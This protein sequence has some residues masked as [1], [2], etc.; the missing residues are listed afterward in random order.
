M[1]KIVYIPIENDDNEIKNKEIM[2]YSLKKIRSFCD[3]KMMD[4]NYYD[5][6]EASLMRIKKY[7]GKI[8][9]K[10]VKNELKKFIKYIIFDENNDI[11]NMDEKM[12]NKNDIENM[13]DENI[14]ENMDDKKNDI[15]NMDDENF[16][17]KIY[18]VQI[19]YVVVRRDGGLLA[20]SSLD[21]PELDKGKGF[22]LYV[23]N[24][25][26]YSI[27]KNCQNNM[28]IFINFYN[29]LNYKYISC[30]ELIY[31]FEI[32]FD[33]KKY[34]FFELVCGEYFKETIKKN[35]NNNDIYLFFN[36]CTL[37]CSYHNNIVMIKFIKYEKKNYV[38]ILKIIFVFMNMMTII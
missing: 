16:I 4:M 33:A 37:H 20:N 14:N 34:G 21:A 29:S 32:L 30:Y 13:D 36:K 17:L 35:I 27:D 10:E 24:L 22:N 12:D 11:E 3:K 2:Y 6:Y 18:D 15:E 25:C 5:K 38:F 23:N 1:Y 9:N 19:R 28:Q 31:F 8:E 7:I 26:V